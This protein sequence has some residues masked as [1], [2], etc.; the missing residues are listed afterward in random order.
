VHI[1]VTT[2]ISSA[3]LDGMM[4]Y[5][6]AVG[7]AISRDQ[8]ADQW[9]RWHKEN[10]FGPGLFCIASHRNRVVGFYG[11]IALLMRCDGRE[12]VGGKGEYHVVDPEY[13][14]SMVEGAPSQL[15]LA[16]VQRAFGEGAK[17]GMAILQAVPTLAGQLSVY[18]AGGVPMN[19]EYAHLAAFPRLAGMK[20][21]GEWSRRAHP[22]AYSLVGSVLTQGLRIGSLLRRHLARRAFRT[23]LDFPPEALQPPTANQMVAEEPRMLAFRFPAAEY[24]T[25]TILPKFGDRP[26]AQFVLD[27]SGRDGV[28]HLHHW[29]PALPAVEVWVAFLD[30]VIRLARGWRTSML[31]FPV[32]AYVRAE[33]PAPLSLGFFEWKVRHRIFLYSCDAELVRGLA[34]PNRWLLTNSHTGL[35][36]RT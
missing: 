36:S 4:L 5:A 24:V 29:S 9:L 12:I 27:R 3:V 18:A 2:E 22:S 15:P 25:V 7:L 10:P 19:V 35:Y 11:L 17:H 30:A 33:M 20:W 6:Q 26:V 32:P 34:D 23:S 28:V 13:R 16:L 21:A 1:R 14:R 8:I 31:L